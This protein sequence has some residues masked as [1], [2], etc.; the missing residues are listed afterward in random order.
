MIKDPDPGC[1]YL[2]EDALEI[3]SRN[4]F[5]K[6]RLNL[7]IFGRIGRVCSR[8]GLKEWLPESYRADPPVGYYL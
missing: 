1:L 3:F 7:K 5:K 6:I 2:S 4:G 8:L